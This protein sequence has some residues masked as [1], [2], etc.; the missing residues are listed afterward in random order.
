M[1]VSMKIYSDLTLALPLLEVI[2]SSQFKWKG[3][4]GRWCLKA[5]R[6]RRNRVLSH[7]INI[8]IILPRGRARERSALTFRLSKFF[9]PFL[10]PSAAGHGCQDER[11]FIRFRGRV[12]RCRGQTNITSASCLL[13]SALLVSSQ[14]RRLP[15]PFFKHTW[16]QLPAQAP[17]GY[18][19]DDKADNQDQGKYCLSPPVA[20]GIRGQSGYT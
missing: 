10:C 15:S 8:M 7:L 13:L 3:N 14:K 6:P 19:P 11:T 16:P 5:F 2:L 1:A 12:I 17:G 4:P 20:A 18:I 9:M